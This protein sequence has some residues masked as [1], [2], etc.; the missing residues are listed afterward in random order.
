M[1]SDHSILKRGGD[2]HCEVVPFVNCELRIGH[3]QAI[4]LQLTSDVMFI[5]D[6]HRCHVMSTDHSPR[7]DLNPNSFLN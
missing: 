7:F 4:E 2:L 1:V 5:S 3:C 6:R